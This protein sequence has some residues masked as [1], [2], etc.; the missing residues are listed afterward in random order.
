MKRSLLLLLSSCLCLLIV[1]TGCGAPSDY[2]ADIPVT[3][4]PTADDPEGLITIDNIVITS[5]TLDRDYF[6]PAAGQ[7]TA[8]EPCFLVSLRI[9]NGY[10][11]DCWVTFSVDG[12]N[13]SGNQVS[14]TLDTG[15]RAGAWQVYLASDSSA[16]YTL[17]LSWAD[18]VT[19]MIIS[20]DRTV[21]IA[22]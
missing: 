20:S 14:F 8:G 22:P 16:E 5:G 21:R 19:D 17:H 1:F 12:F 2:P 4:E 9:I 7:H 15:P 6:T 3:V 10:D 13:T 11:E 18:S